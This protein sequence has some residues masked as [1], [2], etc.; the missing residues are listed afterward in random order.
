[1]TLQGPPSDPATAPDPTPGPHGADLVGAERVVFF[2]DAVVAIALTLLVLPLMEAAT[3]IGEGGGT[4]ADFL[5]AHLVQLGTFALSFVVIT[6]FW[7]AHHRICEGLE[8]ATPALVRWN[9]LWTF[10]IVC[11]PVA[12]ALSGTTPVDRPQLAVYI[13]TLLIA[14]AALTGLGRARRDPRLGPAVPGQSRQRGAPTTTI[15]LVVVLGLA[16]AWPGV[17][18]W[19]LLLLVVTGPLAR[20]LG[21]LRRR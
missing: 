13:G 7:R 9:V 17:N 4:T 3:A 8:R 12:T 5:R 1:M 18:Y 14:A 11:L 20:L 21:R 15:T 2:T 16:L 6:T 19:W 10:A